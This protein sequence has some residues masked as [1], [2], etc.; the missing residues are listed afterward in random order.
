[1]WYSLLRLSNIDALLVSEVHILFICPYF[2]PISSF[3]RRCLSRY[4]ITFNHLSSHRI[5]VDSDSFSDIP[6]G[7]SVRISIKPIVSDWNSYAFSDYSDERSCQL[8]SAPVLSF[9]NL[10][11][12]IFWD[13]VRGADG[14]TIQIK[15]NISFVLQR[16]FLMNMTRE[17]MTVCQTISF[18]F[19]MKT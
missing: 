4:Q 5:P 2:P 8:I 13:S 16:D 15:H 18:E 12:H 11:T 10:S 14:Y 7:E 6:V 9:E 1:M 19:L 3:C 17:L